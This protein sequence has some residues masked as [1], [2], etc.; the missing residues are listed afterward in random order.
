MTWATALAC[1]G[2]ADDGPPAAQETNGNEPGA[3]APT[4]AASIADAG[5]A[6]GAQAPADAASVDAG[7]SCAKHLTVVFSVGVGAS[8]LA[9]HSNGCWTVVDADGAANHKFRKCSTSNFVVSNP[10]ADNYSYD[11]TNP[12]RPLSQDQNYLSQCSAQATGDGYEFMAYRGGW[13]MLPAHNLVA[14]F[15]ELYGDA[16]TDVDSLLSTSG[17]YDG[18]AQLAAHKNVYPMINIGPPASAHLEAHIGAT[19]LALC[20]KIADH[21][22]FGTYVAT[23]PQGLSATDPRTLAVASALNKCTGL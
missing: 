2:P 4:P 5:P 1:S 3:S 15:A 23:W 17:V 14:Y 8:A 22:Y 21:G 10:Q 6:D 13:R 19:S 9:G 11:D 7:P 18:N 20:K 12:T 16:T